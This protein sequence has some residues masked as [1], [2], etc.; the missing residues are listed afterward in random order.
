MRSA[1]AAGAKA[2]TPPSLAI[3]G[4]GAIASSFHLPALLRHAGLRERL[5]FVDPDATR[6][7]A[8]AAK[9]GGGRTATRVEEVIGAVQGAIIATPHNLHA[10]LAA[11]F[12]RAGVHVLCEKPVA[13]SGRELDDVIAAAA[14]GG[15]HVA[16]NNNRRLYPSFRRVR[17]LLTEGAVGQVREIRLTLGEKFDWPAA[18]GF[19]FGRNSG[20]HGVVADTGAHVLDLL[21]WW[22]GGEPEL[23]ECRDDSFGGS[24]A[25]AT[26]HCRRDGIEAH[27]HLSW[28]SKLENRYAI[29]GSRGSISGEMYD[30]RTITRTGSD[31]VA[32]AVKCAKGGATLD[33]VGYDLVDSFVAAAGGGPAPLVTVQDVAPSVR[34]TEKYYASRTAG[35]L[36]W[37]EAGMEVVR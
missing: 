11:S 9:A 23:L 36:P 35:P 20:G 4:C 12:A 1:Q 6:A 26:I 13:A 32:H 15:V 24:E 21:C 18:S 2:P 5:I 33:E 25:E 14:T 7:Q 37:H 22:L 3:V 34:M 31:N 27:V 28:L 30:W 16:V 17:D 8:L 19:Y 10:E 29:V